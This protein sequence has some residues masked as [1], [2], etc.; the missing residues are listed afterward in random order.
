MKGSINKD[1]IT[2]IDV[3]FSS[4]LDLL[5]NLKE[6]ADLIICKN[7]VA[8]ILY[9]MTTNELVDEIHKYFYTNYSDQRIEVDYPIEY[10]KLCKI[11]GCVIMSK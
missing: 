6:D 7:T 9:D 4:L 5:L 2:Y 8:D 11:F 1:K 3:R 10:E